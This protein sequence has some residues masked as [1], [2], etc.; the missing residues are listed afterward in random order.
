MST[1]DRLAAAR[2]RKEQEVEMSRLNNPTPMVDEPGGSASRLPQPVAGTSFLTEVSSVEDDIQRLNSNVA[3]ISATRTRY[4]TAVD[5]SGEREN[6]I[7]ESLTTE[8]RQLTQTIKRRIEELERQVPLRDTQIR[9][10]QLAVVRKH[11]LDAI[12]NYQRVEHEGDMRSRLH[13]SKQLHIVKPDATQDEVQE[14]IEGGGQQV[15]AEALTT[16]TRYGES[17]LAYKE[18]QDR[19]RDVQRMEKT[20]GELAQLFND[21]AIL[22]EQQDQTINAVEQTAV[23]VNDN[24]RAALGETEQ[25]IVHARRYRRGRWICFGIFVLVCVVLAIVLGVVFG[26]RK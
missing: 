3:R 20:L 19:Q 21:M 1:I 2:R 15:F 13:I 8:S 23:D 24:T 18:V 22:V 26:T 17:R 4:L 11:F 7:L 9:K 14:F 25:A 12:Q 5:S 10:N 6:E 16:S